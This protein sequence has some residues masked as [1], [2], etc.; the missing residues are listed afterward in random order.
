MNDIYQYLIVAKTLVDGVANNKVANF[1]Y[2]QTAYTED[3]VDGVTEYSYGNDQNIPLGSHTDLEQNVR[4]KGIRSQAASLPR[5]AINH[6][7]GRVSYNLNKITDTLNSFIAQ[8]TRAFTQNGSFY[9]ALAEYKQYDTCTIF[10]TEDGGNLL[11]TFL[12]TSSVP[13]VIQGVIP[14]SGGVINT[15]HWKLM[16]STDTVTQV[17]T[18]SST[19]IASTELV[20][21][22]I[23]AY[24]SLVNAS[25]ATKAPVNHASENT[26]YG[27]AT[28]S[29]Y[30]H[31]K[32]ANA[33]V[34]ETTTVPTSAILFA[35]NNTLT[36]SLS[37][38]ANLASPAFTG[39][40][41]VNGET[42]LHSGSTIVADTATLAGSAD[43]VNFVLAPSSVVSSG[44]QGQIA[45]SG[46]YLYICVAPNNWRRVEAQTW[47]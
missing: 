15:E 12:R 27:V 5:N 14:I 13:E 23:A 42:I 32:L 44:T 8:I 30:G 18:D 24:N 46:A 43:K 39:S 33:L 26:S 17:T 3:A 25:L 6:F 19:K 34:N 31:I 29:V 7:F 11:K 20:D 16:Y 40:P 37:A 47:G 35:I 41:T 36:N 28:T 22:K 9:S 21:N 38:K 1:A 2:T 10:V 45:R 4:D